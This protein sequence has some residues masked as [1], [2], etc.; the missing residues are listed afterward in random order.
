MSKLFRPRL[1][2]HFSLSALST[3]LQEPRLYEKIK[4]SKPKY[5]IKIN[6]GTDGK[7]SSFD[8]K[9]Y[10]KRLRILE[11]SRIMTKIIHETVAD[12]LDGGTDVKLRTIGVKGDDS[13]L[14]P[15]YIDQD[16]KLIVELTTT[17][18]VNPNNVE[19]RF[20]QKIIH[21]KDA[22]EGTG[23]RI[24][25]VVVGETFVYTN[26]AV[27][28]SMVD[29]LCQRC[30][31]GIAIKSYIEK[32]LGYSLSAQ[33]N[34]EDEKLVYDVI[35]SMKEE[36]EGN[37]LFPMKD[38]MN[39][40]TQPTREE[41]K[42]ALKILKTELRESKKKSPESKELV[43]NYISSYTGT[44]RTDMKRVSNIPMIEPSVT[45]YDVDLLSSEI[46]DSNM[47]SWLKKIWMSS[48]DPDL[49]INKS[50]FE[51]TR[52]QILEEAMTDMKPTDDEKH[53]TQKHSSFNV[54]LSAEDLEEASTTGLFGKSQKSAKLYRENKHHNKLSFHPVDTDTSDIEEFITKVNM[55]ESTH[56]NGMSSDIVRLLKDAKSVWNSNSDS[57]SSLS[58]VMLKNITKTRMVNFGSLITKLFT[59]ICYCYKYWIGRSD[60]YVKK[61]DGVRILIRCTGTHIFCSMAYPKEIYTSIDTGRLGPTLFESTEWYFTDIVSYTEP[62]VEHFVKAGPYLAA[63]ISHQMCSMELDIDSKPEASTE[64]SKDMNGI[65]LLYLNNKTDAEEIM[66][67]QRYLTM[68]VLEDLD[69]NPYRFVD[70]LPDFIKSRLS[71]FLVK[72]TLN[73][74][75]R[76]STPP[77]RMIIKEGDIS[78][79]E[80]DGLVSFFSNEPISFKRKIEEFYYGYVISKEK[81]RGGDR[82]F[83]IMKKIVQQ[84]YKYRDDNHDQFSNTEETKTNQT[85]IP[86]LKVL[87]FLM[88]ERFEEN[89][90]SS[91]NEVMERKII[92]RLS[93]ITFS[94]LATL[95]V[96]SRSYEGELKV[97]NTDATMTTEEVKEKLVALNP[98]DVASRPRVMES[99]TLL[100]EQYKKE[101]N[102]T[103]VRHIIQLVPWCL[104]KIESRGYFYSDIFPKP[105]H[106]GD[107]EIHVLE[108]T[109]RICQLF[110]EHI[111]RS[112]CEMTSSDTLMH[113]K[114]K[115]TF[116][117]TH[118]DRAESEL[119]TYRI[120][121]GKSA[122]AAK[123]CQRNHSSKFAA[124][125]ASFL[126]SWMIHPV[127]RILK[128]WTT[129]VI[130]F[131]IQFVANFISN[132]TTKS[133]PIYERMR[134]EFFEGT[135]IFKN[136]V[137]NRM[138]IQSGMMQGILHYSSSFVHGII[139]EAMVI[140]QTRV[141]K[142]KE[143]R[144]VITM[145]QGS[146][147][148]AELISVCGKNV[149]TLIRSAVTMLHWKE[150][151]SR[152]IAIYTS[153]AKSCIGS[154]DMIEYNS[155]WY[156]R[157]SSIMPTFRWVSACLEIGVVEKF[158]DRIHNF[159]GTTTNVVEAGG[160]IL[161]ASMIQ[162]CQGWMHYHMLGIGNHKISKDASTLLIELKD[163]A[164][165]YF[166][167]DSDFNAGITGVDFQLYK[168]FKSSEY[169]YGVG[170]NRLLQAEIE[171][172]NEDT[173]D[174]TV[175]QSLRRI[176]IKFGNNRIFMDLL[177]RMSAP[178]LEELLV[179]VDKNP[180]ILYY[181]PRSWN[182]SKLTIFMKLFEPGV[183]ESLSRHSATARVL[184]ASAYMLSRPCFTKA[185]RSGKI[186]LFKALKLE[187]YDRIVGKVEKPEIEDVFLYKD[188]YE[189]TLKD[190]ESLL[191]NS[192]FQRVNLKSRSKQT[193]QVFNRVIN[194]TPI[195]EMCKEK[196]FEEGGKT[197]LTPRQFDIKW[198]DLK[199]RFSFLKDSRL[200]TKKL[201]NLNEVQLKNFLVSID[202][203]PR[204]LTLMDTA[205]KGSSVRSTM[206]RLFW[207]NLKILKTGSDISEEENASSIRSK[208]FAI[209][210]HWSSAAEKHKMIAELF[211]KS[212]IL[213]QKT[214]PSRLRKTKCISDFL[215]QGKKSSIMDMI[216]SEKIG[217]L[218]VFTVVQQGHGDNRYGYGEWKGQVLT[219]DVKIELDGPYCT[220]IYVNTL[221]NKSELGK[222]L[223]ELLKNMRAKFPEELTESSYWLSP[224]GVINGGR[225][226]MK[227]IPIKVLPEMKVTIF[228]DV[229]DWE[230][231]LDFGHNSLRLRANSGLKGIYTLISDPFRAYE[232]D[233][234]YAMDNKIFGNWNNSQPM[235]AEEISNELSAFF[236]GNESNIMKE[237]AS[238]K[239][240]NR[241]AVSAS[242]WRLSDFRK[243]LKEFFS[244]NR[245]VDPDIHMTPTDQL[246]TLDLS[247]DDLM[248]FQ[249]GDF[250]INEVMVE[251]F[252]VESEDFEFD[253]N[254]NVEEYIDEHLELLLTEREVS[255]QVNQS[256]M[257]PTNRCLSSLDGLSRALSGMSLN[258]L[259]ND[260]I[261]NPEKKYS[262]LMGKILTLVTDSPRILREISSL[263]RDV[264]RQEED[265][266]SATMS[267]RT[268]EDLG[269]LNEREIRE[270][271]EE[272]DL[273][274]AISKQSRVKE[275][276]LQTRQRYVN[277]LNLIDIRDGDNGVSKIPARDLLMWLRDESG[278]FN[279][280][281][282][283]LFRLTDSAYILA[284][285]DRL[286]SHV[287]VM[288]KNSIIS[289]Y[290]LSLYRE[291]I[292]KP[293][294][295]TLFL[296][297][298][299]N[300]LGI[301]LVVGSYYTNPSG[302]VD[303]S[304]KP[305]PI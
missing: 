209:L 64:L 131:P 123:W 40:T 291:A 119:D 215:K 41:F 13:K 118:Y 154:S 213:N 285:R 152:H 217:N 165:G 202:S 60:F 10:G 288:C 248:F 120:T 304:Y 35:K 108:V 218:G 129:K 301:D 99:M 97:P 245:N 39:C 261:S 36:A 85:N 168:Y 234:I 249:T 254:F 151:V 107:R 157:K 46:S 121:L 78:V 122:D 286:D 246:N 98:D 278:Y 16:S 281:M 71:A 113:P 227:A 293:H 27:S 166:P 65:L 180:D 106:G 73:L 66:T 6:V 290:E 112:L 197:G 153:R 17:V 181:K 305:E 15:D 178:E 2:S 185:G 57:K 25:V 241:S 102:T 109:M 282:G 292:V 70:R 61:V 264:F 203:R 193:I 232:W 111:A 134:K 160:K 257:P 44:S 283:T 274:I 139:Q 43:T 167:V 270:N 28:Q 126:P 222:S 103:D 221:K 45:G 299:S 88:K 164:L 150:N 279:K 230:W 50:D 256:T 24:G 142:T 294:L 101:T 33:D 155:E 200:E 93:K 87:C 187:W 259:Y 69:P 83:K 114:H 212:E 262:G 20:M 26:L 295:T 174:P 14:T 96:S 271:I 243:V 179:E 161:E 251:E 81:G 296:D 7:P 268:I 205:A 12:L 72:R 277:M 124:I 11:G 136:A 176:R 80:Y 214:V 1:D 56:L 53:R 194:D 130:C 233:P 211:S 4:S 3:E 132:R 300:Y 191:K 235:N 199:E 287:E 196:W 147:D 42:I 59:E 188:E 250:D 267:L 207:P 239:G 186:S 100:I 253:E 265:S 34:S 143:I 220:S 89:Y 159:Y 266:I 105:Q 298:F 77:I 223:I 272:I 76:Y 31:V 29:A 263:E 90:G 225:G 175:S 141:L 144:S 63:L 75:K 273:M 94:E 32:F 62:V 163:P 276:L 303:Y 192:V 30:R 149:K 128:L 162:L 224:D 55:L 116:V 169:G 19:E 242:G 173:K 52:E 47:P 226:A 18:N 38:I 86:I 9:L 156:T 171:M 172:F 189:D 91:W 247:A 49:E 190:V 138:V 79:M 8:I 115:S 302:D 206:T 219:S 182:G 289:E 5:D 37:R 198:R 84:E 117:K 95:K 204:K 135:G 260:C 231:F 92:E 127:L 48:N 51:R 54:K 229:L 184:S 195:I 275:N 170:A 125:F 68:T 258:E 58:E 177:R 183:K 145:A 252:N 140:L 208:I 158:I 210:T 237:L 269:N 244:L 236:N 238:I 23:Y 228:D 255:M 137:S 133:N 74:M 148:S 216:M 284:L 110:V 280:E 240:N 82:N 21:Y 22:I 297:V 104:K 67:S 146:D 201:L